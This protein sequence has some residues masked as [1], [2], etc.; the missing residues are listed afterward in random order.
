MKYQLFLHILL[1]DSTFYGTIINE[2]VTNFYLL[3]DERNFSL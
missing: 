2:E 1:T 3:S